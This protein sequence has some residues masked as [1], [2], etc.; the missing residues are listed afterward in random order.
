MILEEG[1]YDEFDDE[2]AFTRRCQ[3]LLAFLSF[4]VL[5]TVFCLIIWGAARPYKAE[6]SVKSLTVNNIYGGEGAD[7]TGVPT[8]MLTLN[9]SLRIGVYNPATFFGIHVSSTP[10]N[11][12]YSEITVATGQLKKHYQPRKSH[13]IVLVNLQG[14]KVPLYGAG[15]GL[16]AY[17][18]NSYQIPLT[19]QFNIQSQGYVVGKLVRTKHRAQISCPLVIDSMSTKPIKFSKDSCL[20]L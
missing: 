3:G 7:S 15:S 13:R 12:V 9:S 2:K 4:V 16:V 18:N 19:L 8:K 10:I 6:F 20:Y 14:T 11:L 17:S 5:F 1:K